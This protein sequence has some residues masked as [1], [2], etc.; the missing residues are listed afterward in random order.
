MKTESIS[1]NSTPRK[2]EISPRKLTASSSGEEK[3]GGELGLNKVSKTGSTKQL[4]KKTIDFANKK[5]GYYEVYRPKDECEPIIFIAKKGK[6]ISSIDNK[7]KSKKDLSK[8]GLVDDISDSEL[9]LVGELYQ[10]VTKEMNINSKTGHLEKQYIESGALKNYDTGM[11]PSDFKAMLAAS[12]YVKHSAEQIF[13]VFGEGKQKQTVYSLMM[14]GESKLFHIGEFI[15]KGG[16]GTVYKVWDIFKNEIYILKETSVYNSIE[17]FDNKTPTDKEAAFLLKYNTNSDKSGIQS[18]PHLVFHIAGKETKVSG[19]ITKRYDEDL[20][21][22]LFE[23][24]IRFTTEQIIRGFEQICRGASYLVKINVKNF[25][26]K[27]GN[28]F[29][30]RLS[31]DSYQFDISDYDNVVEMTD[32]YFRSEAFAKD[33]LGDVSPDSITTNEIEWVRMLGKAI[34]EKLREIDILK[35]KEIKDEIARLKGDDIKKEIDKLEHEAKI[36]QDELLNIKKEIEVLSDAIQLMKHEMDDTRNPLSI[37]K[38]QIKIAEKEKKLDE[39]ANVFQAE[40]KKRAEKLAQ[41]SAKEDDLKNLKK[42]NSVE[43]LFK[44]NRIKKQIESNAVEIS[45]KEAEVKILQE[46]YRSIVIGV[47]VWAVAAIGFQLLLG[48]K[49]QF[50]EEINSKSINDLRDEIN[51]NSRGL[52]PK[53]KNFRLKMLALIEEGLK[54]IEGPPK[55]KGFSVTPETEIPFRKNAYNINCILEQLTD[56]RQFYVQMCSG[57]CF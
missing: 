42:K 45:K 7:K 17:F 5:L 52:T 29:V 41:K 28:I 53:A 2:P 36:S 46:K 25:D 31:D 15:A 37:H 3:S 50:A 19:F 56:I 51:G 34:I 57:F 16:V 8:V 39:K 40:D 47:Q 21:K 10:N 55:Q 11:T 43:I 14:E 6:E 4:S 35:G 38:F 9:D 20:S 54:E 18:P 32:D 24:K 44:E 30:K 48:K 33:P 27:S 1:P 22:L 12:L 26:L 13:K 23:E 49:I